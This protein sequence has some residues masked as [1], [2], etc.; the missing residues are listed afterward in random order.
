VDSDKIPEGGTSTYILH[1]FGLAPHTGLHQAACRSE[2]STSRT[3]SLAFYR[4]IGCATS[5]NIFKG[6]IQ[7][8][9]WTAVRVFLLMDD[10][11]HAGYK[12]GICCELLCAGGG[13]RGV[14]RL[15]CNNWN[16]E[17][18]TV[19]QQMQTQCKRGLNR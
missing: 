15:N 2:Q 1:L 5:L 10:R 18:C 9:D 11:C 16:A 6:A 19:Q 14:H 12:K 3:S 4:I 17:V 7:E 8:K 13:K